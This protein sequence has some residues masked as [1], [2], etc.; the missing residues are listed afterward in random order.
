MVVTL[1]SIVCK[2]MTENKPM[3]LSSWIICT[4]LIRHNVGNLGKK[5]NNKHGIFFHIEY[6]I[7]TMDNLCT[8]HVFYY[9][10]VIILCVLVGISIL[11]LFILGFFYWRRK[12]SDDVVFFFIKSTVNLYIKATQGEPENVAFIISSCPLYTG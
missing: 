1:V 11:S 7:A 10:K 8:C 9:C 4:S 3:E 5:N 6:I 12:C 2:E